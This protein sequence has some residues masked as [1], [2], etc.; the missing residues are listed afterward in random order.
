[1]DVPTVL[2]T[3]A[4]FGSNNDGGAEWWWPFRILMIVFWIAVIGFTA[5]WIVWGRRNRGMSA[6]DSARGVLAERY[7][8]GE[9]DADE[10]RQRSEQLRQVS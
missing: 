8:R 10:Y 1:M 5:R 3:M 9:I 7:A 6:V 4:T 2:Y